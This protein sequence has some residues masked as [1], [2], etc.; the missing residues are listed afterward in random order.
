MRALTLYNFSAHG[1]LAARRAT[2]S[3]RSGG[4]VISLAEIG[5]RVMIAPGNARTQDEIG[6]TFEIAEVIGDGDDAFVSVKDAGGLIHKWFRMT[7]LLPASTVPAEPCTSG[8]TARSATGRSGADAGRSG[9]ADDAS[10]ESGA[11]GSGAGAG[12]RRRP[13]PRA[14][15]PCHR[16]RPGGGAGAAEGARSRPRARSASPVCEGRRSHGRKSARTEPK[17]TKARLA[18]RTADRR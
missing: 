3:S 17:R 1:D 5:Q 13:L 8:I 10:D 18:R 9:P 2:P 15:R 4:N 11:S 16:A 12:S 14:G 6:G 7:E